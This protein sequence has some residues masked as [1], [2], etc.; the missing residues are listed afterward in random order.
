M[1]R[2]A[3][4]W[5]QQNPDTSLLYKGKMHRADLRKVNLSQADLRRANLREVPLQEM[6][7]TTSSL[8]GANLSGTR[9]ELAYSLE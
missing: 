7:N 6:K 2:T 9:S 8:Q 5:R 1:W 4:M 3:I